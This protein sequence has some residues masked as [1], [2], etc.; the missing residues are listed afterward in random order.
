[1]LSEPR[2]ISY[3][4]ECIHAPIRHDPQVLKRLYAKTVEEPLLGYSNFNT[5]PAGAQMTAVHG[6][7]SFPNTTSHSVLAVAADRIQL[8]EEWPSISVEDF[9]SKSQLALGLVFEEL[10]IPGFVAV[11]AMVRCLVSPQGVDDCRAWL[12]EQFVG[13]NENDVTSLGRAPGLFGLR[14]AFPGTEEDP[15]LHNVRVESFG[16]D[17]RSVFLEDSA[18]YSGQI[19]PDQLDRI[20]N[21][22]SGAYDFLTGNVMNWLDSNASR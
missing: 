16:G 20:E 7:A 3:I 14:L 12:N 5:G 18:V 8:K 4:L 1:M 10:K 17:N 22:M 2:S 19:A 9:I 11:Q 13:L 6:P 21:A 15:G